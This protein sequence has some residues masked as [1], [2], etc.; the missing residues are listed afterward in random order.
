MNNPQSLLIFFSEKVKFSKVI[1]E[2]NDF[3]RMYIFSSELKKFV[4]ENIVSDIEYKEQINFFNLSTI[5]SKM[6]K[7][8][9]YRKIVESMHT[10]LSG[11]NVYCTKTSAYS[12]CGAK[13]ITLYAEGTGDYIK[14]P[15]SILID[16]LKIKILNG[17]SKLKFKSWCKMPF[18]E[19]SQ[20]GKSAIENSKIN[21]LGIN[22]SEFKKLYLPHSLVPAEFVSEEFDWSSVFIKN[23]YLSDNKGSTEFAGIIST[24]IPVEILIVKLNIQEVYFVESSCFFNLNNVLDVKFTKVVAEDI[25]HKFIPYYPKV[26]IKI[27]NL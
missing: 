12:L 20:L 11:E 17:S 4:V 16:I 21:D 14:P 2:V 25:C 26:V 23:H 22:C 24:V 13:K 27:E 15:F 5:K 18:F 6:S 19:Y 10:E 7:F 8:I 1:F 9:F 3:N